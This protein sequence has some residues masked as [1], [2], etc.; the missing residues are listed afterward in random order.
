[1][2]AKQTQ[3]TEAIFKIL[4]SFGIPANWAKIIGGVI[5]GAA[6]ALYTLAITSCGMSLT[7]SA[8]GGEYQITVSQQQPLNEDT[9]EVFI[10]VSEAK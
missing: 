6:I 8:N 9:T 4:R 1:M 10:E 5:V 3:I 7:A 2:T